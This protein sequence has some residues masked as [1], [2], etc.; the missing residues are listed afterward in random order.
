VVEEPPPEPTRVEEAPNEQSGK[1]ATTEECVDSNCPEQHT[2]MDWDLLNLLFEIRKVLE[3]QVFRMARLEQRL[4]MF[5]AAHSR[6]TPKKQRPTCARV[7]AL[8]A[9]WK[10]S[11]MV[12]DTHQGSEV[13]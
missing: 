1:A 6:A 12:D 5:F 13:I 9:R 7:Y 11:A 10:H 2:S 3:D 8:P 4:D